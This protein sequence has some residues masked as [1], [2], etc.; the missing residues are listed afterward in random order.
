[1]GIYPPRVS[2]KACAHEPQKNSAGISGAVLMSNFKKLLRGFLNRLTRAFHVFTKPMGR[3]AAGE[4][5]LPCNR[6]QK[7]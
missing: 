5:D 2:T 4:D 6:E 1:M 3:M 7:A